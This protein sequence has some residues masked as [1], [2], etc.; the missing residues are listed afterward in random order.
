MLFHEILFGIHS[1][2]ITLLILVAV[3]GDYV[4]QYS[5]LH[6]YRAFFDN[7]THAIIGGLSWLIV[8]LNFK[9]RYSSQTLFEIALCTLAGSFIDLDHFVTARSFNLKVSQSS[10]ISPLSHNL[11]YF[12]GCNEF[13]K[14]STTSLL[15]III[16]VNV[17]CDINCLFCTNKV[18]VKI[19]SDY[20]YCIC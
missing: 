10:Y 13:A 1:Y 9:N 15:I 20:I 18:V 4:V 11:L 2:L 12:S 5:K 6:I 3:T 8:C 7:I 17:A 16:A 19:R 14:S